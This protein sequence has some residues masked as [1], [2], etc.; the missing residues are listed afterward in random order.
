MTY[1][2]ITNCLLAGH[3]RRACEGDTMDYLPETLV[4]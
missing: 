1:E 4:T 3:L 2:E